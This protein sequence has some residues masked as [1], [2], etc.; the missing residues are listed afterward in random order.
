MKKKRGRPYGPYMPCGWGCG[1]M[2]TATTIRRHFTDCPARKKNKSKTAA[3]QCFSCGAPMH[4]KIVCMGA[5]I[6]RESVQVE[7]PAMVCQRCGAQTL[8]DQQMAAYSAATA[9]AY[10]ERH[11][12]LSSS[13]ISQLSR[14]LEQ[15]AVAGDVQDQET[16]NL[17]R[18]LARKIGTTVL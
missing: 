3:I 17:L 12:L 4:E 6:K 9:D 5:S 2:L 1:A 13:Q 18:L 8:T 10:R 16:D 7:S 11:G 15:L 14:W